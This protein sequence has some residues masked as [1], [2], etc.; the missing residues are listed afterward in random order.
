M[1]KYSSIEAYIED[2]EEYMNELNLLREIILTT[3]LDETLKWSAPVYTY[4]GKN[5]LGIGA[6]KKYFGLWFFQGSFLR[7][8]KKVLMN[9]QEG[10][11]RGLRQWRFE[12]A[13]ELD[14]D[15]IRAYIFEAI[16]NQEAGLEVKP[17][18]RDVPLAEELKNAFKQDPELKACFFALTP[19]RQM[20]YSSYISTAKKEE[21]RINRLNKCI[22]LILEGKGLDDQYKS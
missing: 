3:G 22:P 14:A 2:H 8:E 21:T 20:N 1:K 12:D 6:F 10:V 5:I 18:K 13:G 16:E 7:D 19:G 11:T 15:L 17:V 4:K 9:A